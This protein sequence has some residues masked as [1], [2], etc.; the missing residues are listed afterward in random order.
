MVG[1]ENLASNDFRK[2][3]VFVFGG[4]HPRP[5]DRTVDQVLVIFTD[6]PFQQPD[7]R[8]EPLEYQQDIEQKNVQG[9]PLSDMLPLVIGQSGRIR[10]SVRNP[11]E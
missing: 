1:C 2:K 6:R 5:E 11:Q 10:E 4:G 3:Q 7:K 9:M 8:V